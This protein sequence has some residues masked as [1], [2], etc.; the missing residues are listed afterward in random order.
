M[1]STLEDINAVTEVTRAAA[2]CLEK[3]AGS[4]TEASKAAVG[5]DQSMVTDREVRENIAGRVLQMSEIISEVDTM[6]RTISE[7]AT[8]NSA[9]S[10]EMN[11]SIQ[12]IRQQVADVSRTAEQVR[13]SVQRLR[14]ANSRSEELLSKSISRVFGQEV[15]A[16]ADALHPLAHPQDMI[17]I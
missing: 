8:D 10:E 2:E 3:I 12:E 15:S 11:A 16:S 17:K 5:V 6:L 9:A 13:E 4:A 7:G 14:F 1:N